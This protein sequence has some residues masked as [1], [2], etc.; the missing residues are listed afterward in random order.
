ME[1]LKITIDYECSKCWLHE[2]ISDDSS[3][4]ITNWDGDT[5]TRHFR[6]VDSIGNIITDHST[7]QN[8]PKGD[9]DRH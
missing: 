8:K 2:K 3:K 9:P 1:D 4:Y 6:D 7:D 5:N